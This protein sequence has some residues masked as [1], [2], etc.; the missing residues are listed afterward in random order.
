LRQRRLRIQRLDAFHNLR[1]A[2]RVPADRREAE[3]I[4]D[5][6]VRIADSQRC[7]RFLKL[8]TFARAHA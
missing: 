8:P 7:E 5:P 2:E 6:A 3:L 1:S 4:A